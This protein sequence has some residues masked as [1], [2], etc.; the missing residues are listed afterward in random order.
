M[1]SKKTPQKKGLDLLDDPFLN[2]GTA[3]TEQE[4][5]DLNLHGLLPVAQETIQEQASRVVDRIKNLSSNLEKYVTLR[6][7]QN[8][9]ETLFY[10][11]VTNHLS[12]TLPIIYTPTVG[13][14]C[15]HFSHIY[16]RP[17]GLFLSYSNKDKIQRILDNP[18]FDN[19]S[20]IVV[21]DGERILGLGDQ[22]A[23]GMGISIGKLSLYTAC[24]GI[25]PQKTLP[26]LLDTGTDNQT[27]LNDPQYIGWR[28]PRIRNQEYDD[29]IEHFV[30]AV[31]KRFP[32]VLLQ[33]EDFAQQNA[34]RIL[35]K[36]RNKL[37]SFND[38]IQGTAAIVTSAL[39]SAI[40]VTK[41]SLKNQK[42]VVVGGGSAGC[43][44][45]QMILK[46]MMQEGLSQKEALEKFFV[47]DRNGLFLNNMDL[48]PF[49]KPFTKTLESIALWTLENKTIVSLKD[50]IKNVHPT[51][52]IGVSGQ[53]GI[54]TEEIIKE[55]AK[56]VE[57]PIILPLSNPTSKAEATPENLIRWTHGKA[58]IGTGS[59]FPDVV[60][61][62]QHFKID[63]INNSYIFPG[64][65]LGII[66]V[67]ASFVSDEMFMA[68]ATTLTNLSPSKQDPK[69]NL[70][71]SLEKIREISLEI[72]FA[73]AQCAV[74]QKLAQNLSD[75]EIRKKIKHIFWTPQY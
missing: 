41:S 62:N 26:I 5:T 49:Q 35:E 3:F 57:R 50:T 40:K 19:T 16:T 30:S 37:C 25:H 14:G 66:A 32:K 59:P 8:T 44:I 53:P 23:G 9:N 7:I 15:V 10:F 64:L 17:R 43:G 31:K 68:A 72:A 24:A 28:H 70:L 6:E 13:E 54:F 48:L 18:Q 63:Q 22:G 39:L 73:V 69:R 27:L 67:E 21:S 46:K 58:F 2:K 45:S 47:I 29:F 36:Y 12:L 20:V 74:K 65:G 51:V 38:D 60:Q 75:D 1:S 42:I 4:R 61:G 11:I 33:W 55:M 52:L 34:S 71:P 56:H